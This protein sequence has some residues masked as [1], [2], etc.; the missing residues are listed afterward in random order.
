M[1]I[2]I[3]GGTFNPPH[4]G[5]LKTAEFVLHELKLSKLIFIPSYITP[6]KEGDEQE[7]SDHRLQMTNFMAKKNQRFECSDI[8]IQRKGKSFTVDTILILKKKY[9]QEKLFL[10][11]GADNY[12]S[13]H[14]WK[15]P[16][17]ILECTT[18]TVMTRPTFE[19]KK[20]EFI[21]HENIIFITV[22]AVH[23]SSSEI[24]DKVKRGESIEEF[25]LPE[26]LAYIQRQRLYK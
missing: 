2:G 10:I 22:P 14:K 13:F 21:S 18:L 26:V 11:I 5:H 19:I 4:L 15:E 16:E 24:R 6:L 12:S 25:V 9:L 20:N 3:L 7:L 8:E 1:N 23:I 17:K